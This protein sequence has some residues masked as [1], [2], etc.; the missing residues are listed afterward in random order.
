MAKILQVCNT[1]FYLDRFLSP[2]VRA[3]VQAGHE[4]ECVC[5]ISNG[6]PPD[7]GVP[8]HSLPFPSKGSLAQFG[9]AVLGMRALIARGGYDCVNSHNRNA[10]IVARVAA[11]LER[12][13]INLYT[14]HGYYFHDDQSSVARE[15]TVYLEAALARIT[16]YT[17]SQSA[18][19]TALMVRRGYVP[20]SRIRTIG[21]GIDTERFAPGADR[22]VVEGELGLAAGKRRVASVGRLVTG[23]GFSDLL[24]AFDEVHRTRPDAELVIIGGNIAQDIS[25][26]QAEFMGEVRKRG[27]EGAVQITGIT[28]RVPDYLAAVD[29]F[30]LPSYREGLP[31]SLI[32]AMSMGLP[33]IATDIRGC[34][35]AVE[36]GTSGYLYP[37]H[38]WR[39]LARHLEA[40]LDDPAH[41]AALGAAARARAVEQFDEGGYVA[42]Q[43]ATLEHLI[44]SCVAR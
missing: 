30:V 26:Y 33:V 8:V 4:V 18:E 39:A 43:V 10:S 44:D 27:L 2:L 34:R 37:P 1:D 23:K 28:N 20:P 5:E 16:D 11:W 21:N 19:D 35:E 3:L 15:A 40:V 31:R 42:K 24:C 13:P 7:L 29:V 12:V 6:E 9:K 41:A 38:D 25:P 32:E 22:S 17:L 36:V 14:A